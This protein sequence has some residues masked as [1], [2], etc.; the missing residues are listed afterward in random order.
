[1]NLSQSR[2]ESPGALTHHRAVTKTAWNRGTGL[3][4]TRRTRPGDGLT[5]NRILAP[6]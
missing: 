1:M 5:R 6:L 3:Y 2:L 4:R